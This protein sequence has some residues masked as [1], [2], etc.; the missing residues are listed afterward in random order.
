MS[1][2]NKNGDYIVIHKETVSNYFFMSVLAIAFAVFLVMLGNSAFNMV[3]NKPT[4]NPDLITSY[5]DDHLNIYYPIPG[6]DWVMAEVDTT[7]I[8]A[9][10][11]E[12]MGEDEYFS[13]EDD[14]LTKE[15]L[16]SICFTGAGEGEDSGFRQFMSFTFM[17]NSG[18]PDGE[19]L[20]FA[21]SYFE[22]TMADSGTYV[23]Q[24]ITDSYLDENGGVMMKM[25]VVQ[26]VEDEETSKE[27]N[28]TTYYTQYVKVVGENL[29]TVTH[30]SIFEDDSV[31][32]YLQY[33]LNNITT[34]KSLLSEETE[35]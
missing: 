6:A 33:F 2:N 19:L 29:A 28:M 7:E 8:S 34:E 30:G 1:N 26:A 5:K 12:S 24:T 25:E 3:N 13:L 32:M 17:P 35:D 22:K 23:S 10:V 21:I 14:K 4:L 15:V 27:T 20:D 9:T 31:D 11:N 16:S 18:Y